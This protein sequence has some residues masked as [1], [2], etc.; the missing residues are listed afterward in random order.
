MKT[1]IRGSNLLERSYNAIL[2]YPPPPFRHDP[3]PADFYLKL[4]VMKLS[5][6]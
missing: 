2:G 4:F 3:F 5:N 6:H 1:T